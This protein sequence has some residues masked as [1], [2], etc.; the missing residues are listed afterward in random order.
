MFFHLNP[1]GPT[2]GG[3][4]GLSVGGLSD[5]NCKGEPALKRKQAEKGSQD[6]FVWVEADSVHE[7]AGVN[8]AVQ[9]SRF[10]RRITRVTS[11]PACL[12]DVGR[13][14]WVSDCKDPKIWSRKVEWWRWARSDESDLAKEDGHMLANS[15][16]S[17]H[18]ESTSAFLF[19][20]HQSSL[21]LASGVSSNRLIRSAKSMSPPA[22]SITGSPHPPYHN[23][24][25]CCRA[26]L[27]MWFER[28]LSLIHNCTS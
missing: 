23:Q 19:S 1:L 9:I 21:Y 28:R 22:P 7:S 13:N 11:E 16:R 15:D 17:K 8:R 3:S 20:N 6:E 26:G 25:H 10:E 12:Y 14:T 2:Q 24:S 27:V 5:R 4:L 18:P